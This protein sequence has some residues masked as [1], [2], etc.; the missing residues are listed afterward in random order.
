MNLP[1]PLPP[2]SCRRAR[3]RPWASQEARKKSFVDCLFGALRDLHYGHDEGRGSKKDQSSGGHVVRQQQLPGPEKQVTLLDSSIKARAWVRELRVKRSLLARKLNAAL[4]SFHGCKVH[5]SGGEI[6]A[7]PKYRPSWGE[8]TG[9]EPN[10]TVP[11]PA[12]ELRARGG[13]TTSLVLDNLPYRIRLPILLFIPRPAITS[14]P[15]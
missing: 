8:L 2:F 9:L 10:S 13:S 7:E 15:P 3:L 5:A 1:S 6:G 11:Q 4:D 14:R 12:L